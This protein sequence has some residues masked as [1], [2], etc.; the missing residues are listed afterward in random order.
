MFTTIYP[1]WY[2]GRTV[3]IHLRVRLYDAATDTV[4]YNFVTQMFFDDAVTSRIFAHYAPYKSRPVRDTTNT[5]DSVYTGASEDNE[6]TSESGEY[7]LLKLSEDNNLRIGT[8]N[9]QISLS[10]S[11]YNDATGGSNGGP[12][13]GGGAPPPGTP[14][15]GT[16]PTG[17]P[18]TSTT[19]S[20]VTSKSTTSKTKTKTKN[21]RLKK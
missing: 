12:V 14:P 6:V 3:H 7:L 16:P 18:P 15:T 11:G 10:D 13:G 9:V 8:F 21:V 17:T 1:G 2:S 20:A 4:T 19:T 5:T